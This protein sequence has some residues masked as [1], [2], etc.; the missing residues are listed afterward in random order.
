MATDCCSG[1]SC[2]INDGST[3]GVTNT[4]FPEANCPTG[5]VIK[6]SL[7]LVGCKEQMCTTSDC[8]AEILCSVNDGIS[9]GVPNPVS[10]FSLGRCETA[11][12]G[13]GLDWTLK[14][15]QGDIRCMATD[16]KCTVSECCDPPITCAN[17]DGSASG[18]TIGKFSDEACQKTS[19]GG[20]TGY[21]LKATTTTQLSTFSCTSNSKQCSAT[22]CCDP[23]VY[24][25]NNDGLGTGVTGTAFK[26]SSCKDPIYGGTEG[27]IIKSSLTGVSC[28]TDDRKCT[29]DECC[30]MISC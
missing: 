5:Y 17:N 26:S 12:V 19:L 21:T 23:P 24:C 10:P 7:S 28:G 9:A 20:G 16:K 6:G 25:S 1:V 15:N 2:A 22:I 4:S 27:Y 13:G 8:C 14:A 29:A 11:S 18:L 30:D 3:A